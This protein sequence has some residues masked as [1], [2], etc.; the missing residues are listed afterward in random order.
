M[1]EM[2]G[3]AEAP[4][5]ID[6]VPEVAEVSPI[7]TARPPV[8]LLEDLSLSPIIISAWLPSD[9][10]A[11]LSGSWI[12]PAVDVD[13]GA[14]PLRTFDPSGLEYSLMMARISKS[15]A[16]SKWNELMVNEKSLELDFARSR[17]GD[18]KEALQASLEAIRVAL[19]DAK[20]QLT[21]LQASFVEDPTSLVPWMQTLFDLMDNGLT[22]FEVGG[23]LYPHASLKSLFSSDNAASYYE[24]SE[25]ILGTFKRRCDKERGPGKVQILTRLTPCIF[26]DGYSPAAV[27]ATIERIRTTILGA[28][29]V[30]AIDFAQLFWWSPT[31]LD[32]LPTLR[33]L[34]KLSE[35]K[36]EVNEETGEVTVIEP[37][38]IRGIG[39]VDFPPRALLQAIQAGVPI[40]SVQ[41]PFSLADRRHAST[42]AICRKYGIKILSRDG[43]MGGLINDKYVGNYCPDTADDNLVDVA[44]CVDLINELGGWG[45]VQNL[46]SVVKKIADKHGVSMET[47]ALRWQ[48]DQGTF[49]VVPIQWGKKSTNLFGGEVD[50]KLSVVESFFDVSDIKELNA[51]AI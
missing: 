40:I 42:I 14:L 17:G 44:Y 9:A 23:P 10:K 11:M 46:L 47:V 36:I 7:L 24:A 13:E 41:V 38:K 26:Q 51:L 34:H 6:E 45:V 39:L 4:L 1:S 50:A 28:D 25:K 33:A 43:L 5:P 15:L 19:S 31:D 2:N 48:M 32:V 20:A 29:S 35:D 3:I 49:P 30:D 12:T 22:T 21:E 27:E 16:L 37:K 18:E 8:T